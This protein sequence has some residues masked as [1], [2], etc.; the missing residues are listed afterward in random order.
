[1]GVSRITGWSGT[2]YLDQRG[3]KLIIFLPLP[4]DCLVS[5]VFPSHVLVDRP[6]RCFHTPAIVHTPSV[7][8]GVHTSFVSLS[9]Y[10]PEIAS[11]AY[12]T[13]LGFTFETLHVAPHR[14]QC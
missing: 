13:A 10:V 8:M 4:P 9:T 6:L 12:M 1:M 14:I 3:P 2:H 11:L 5:S 7:S